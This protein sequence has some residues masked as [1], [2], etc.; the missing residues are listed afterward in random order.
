[1]TKRSTCSSG[2]SRNG[3]KMPW[4]EEVREIELPRIAICAAFEKTSDSDL[5]GRGKLGQLDRSNC[6]GQ[7][8]QSQ[9]GACLHLQT[10]SAQWVFT[11]WEAAENRGKPWDSLP[12]SCWMTWSVTPALGSVSSDDLWDWTSDSE[13][14]KITLSLWVVLLHSSSSVMEGHVFTC[15]IW[16][17]F[18]LQKLAPPSLGHTYLWSK[19]Y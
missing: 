15:S 17:E 8:A 10:A 7:T 3:I 1:M 16:E 18:G 9:V 19:K 14:Q 5:G 4:K 2:A 12:Q 13:I 11:T 6:I